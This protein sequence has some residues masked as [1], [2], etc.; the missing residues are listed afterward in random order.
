ML[1]IR[2]PSKAGRADPLRSLESGHSSVII[3]SE[4]QQLAKSRVLVVTSFPHSAAA[5]M[6]QLLT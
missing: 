4:L 6:S 1:V 2:Y 5:F 3:K